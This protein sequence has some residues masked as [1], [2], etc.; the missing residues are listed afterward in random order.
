MSKTLLNAA[1]AVSTGPV[2]SLRSHHDRD[3]ALVQVNITGG[4]ATVE[5]LGR[6]SIRLPF[7]VL[8]TINS[9]SI[10]PVARVAEMQ[11]RVAAVSGATVDADVYTDE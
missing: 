11:A 9:S 8:A 10:V 1:T 6:A 7:L 3:E 4:S 5:I 2:V